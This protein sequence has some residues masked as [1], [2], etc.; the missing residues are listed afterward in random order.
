MVHVANRSDARSPEP[1]SPESGSPWS[2]RSGSGFARS[3]PRL[4]QPIN[5][6][7]S[8]DLLPVDR[9]DSGAWRRRD[10]S[11]RAE[12]RGRASHVERRTRRGSPPESAGTRRSRRGHRSRGCQP[13]YAVRP[14]AS[15]RLRGERPLRARLLQERRDGFARLVRHGRRCAPGMARGA[16]APG[17]VAVLR[18]RHRRRDGSAAAPPEPRAGRGRGRQSPAVERD[19]GARS[20][21]AR[22]I[23]ADDRAVSSADEPRAARLDR[24]VSRLGDSAVRHGSSLGQQRPRLPAQRR[25]GGS[26][27]HVRRQPVGIRLPVQLGRLG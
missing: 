3:R 16:R 9:W 1:A 18:S 17:A 8:R 24:P 13:E 7:A 4:R 6:R 27:G 11:H 20:P 22:S 5:R 2:R 15:R 21:S 23:T 12:R 26:A 25:C 19:A 14:V 10:R